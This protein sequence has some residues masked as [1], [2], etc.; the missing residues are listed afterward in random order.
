MGV[1]AVS[2][3]DVLILS[4]ATLYLAEVVTGKDG[5]WGIFRWLRARTGASGLMT[6]IWCFAP[7]AALALLLVW[8]LVPYGNYPVYVLAIAGV[9]LALRS[10]TGVHHG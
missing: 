8:L 5:P 9:A 1:T 7:Y 3:Q 2:L 4:A 10:Y 6:C